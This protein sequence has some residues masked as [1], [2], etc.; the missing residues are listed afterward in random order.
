VTWVVR[1]PDRDLERAEKRIY[2]RVRRVLWDYEPL[3]ASHAEIFI[4][5]EGGAVRLRGRVRTQPQKIIAAALAERM[6]E[7]SSVTNELIADPEVVRSVAD[8]LAQDE[9]TAPYVIRV[10]APRRRHPARGG[11]QRSRSAGGDGD[12]GERADRRQRAKPACRRQRGLPGDRPVAAEP[13][14]RR[15][16]SRSCY[17]NAPVT[18]TP[19]QSG[20]RLTSRQRRI[21]EQRR[22]I[23]TARTQQRRKRLTWVAGIV[24]VL[25][26]GIALLI[27]LMPKPVTAQG[28]QVPIEGNR[29]HVTQGQVV[30][31][32]NRPPS[33]GDHYDQ[34]SG[35][36][37]FPRGV[38]TGNWVHNLEHGGVVVLYRPDLCDEACQSQLQDVYNSAPSST[39]FPGNR[40]MVITPYQDMDHAI[41]T[42]AWGWLDEMDAVDKERIL[43]FYKAH[44]DKGP[45]QAL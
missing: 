41:A 4:D 26:V 45:E 22:K 9:R 16:E 15:T 44:V 24:A 31:Y 2:S 43:A 14:R 13:T 1:A 25:A 6:G 11:P 27:M 36:G 20:E 28:H 12:R 40:K 3:R 10:L 38:A 21:E 39:L 33:S 34:P 30:P 19:P 5:V 42:V 29:Q 37:V 17:N 8:A 35:Y 7:V 23:E 32:R 18:Q